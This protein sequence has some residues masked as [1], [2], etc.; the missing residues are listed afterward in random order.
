MN[1][2]VIALG[3]LLIDFTPRGKSQ[4]GNNIFEANPGGAPCNV[5]AQCAR[6]EKKTC[7]I[8][9]VGADTFGDFL[10]ATLKNANI[11]TSGLVKTQNC[12][13]TLAFVTL[14]EDGQ[15]EFSFARNNSADTQLSENEVSEELIKSSKILHIGTLSLT[16][17]SARNATIKA[18]EIAKKNSVLVSV[19][20]NLRLALWESEEQAKKQMDFA[21]SYADIIKI[22]NYEVE[23]LCGTSDIQKGALELYEKYNPKIMFVTCG[24]DGA[25]CVKD[26]NV[27]NHG[28]YAANTVDTTGAGDSFCGA[29]LSKLLDMGLDFNKMGQNECCDVVKYANAAASVSTTRYGAICVMPEESEFCGLL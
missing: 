12:F 21:L 13:T 29:A 10:E 14:S 16:H 20:P 11:G 7:F 24:K 6:L 5:L 25:F 9:K 23:F 26:G 4:S 17:E 22:S 27:V 8:G 19:D 1:Y 3:E 28:G 2:D 18:L 15:R